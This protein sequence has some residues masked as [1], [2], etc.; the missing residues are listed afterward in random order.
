M[1][2]YRVESEHVDGAAICG[3][4]ERSGRPVHR[5]AG[6]DDLTSGLKRVRSRRRPARCLL[7]HEYCNASDKVLSYVHVMYSRVNQNK[8]ISLILYL[9]ETNTINPIF[10]ETDHLNKTY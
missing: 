10:P 8:L 4:H 3:E 1:R 9:R 2:A 7:T 5:V 6:R